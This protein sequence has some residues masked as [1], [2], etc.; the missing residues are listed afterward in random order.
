MMGLAQ[1][2]L[3]L[4]TQHGSIECHY[5]EC[6]EFLD[7]FIVI[8]SVVRLNVFM[9]SDG[10]AYLIKKIPNLREKSFITLFLGVSIIKLFCFVPNA[11]GK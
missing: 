6:A 5:V 10:V 8:L 9:L 4:G 11:A 2:T 1:M 3:T 7:F